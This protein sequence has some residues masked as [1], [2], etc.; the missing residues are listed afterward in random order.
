MPSGE[1][2]DLKLL[3]KNDLEQYVHLEVNDMSEA[4]IDKGVRV[5]SAMLF[6]QVS[7]Y[8][9][10]ADEMCV[11]RAGYRIE[12]KA[13]DS[14]ANE[15]VQHYF[16][17]LIRTM[18][19]TVRV[20]LGAY[21]CSA[22]FRTFGGTCNNVQRPTWG[23]VRS[24]L[25]RGEHSETVRGEPVDA[26][27]RQ[28][29]PNVRTVSREIFSQTQSVLSLRKV[30]MMAVF[31]GQYIDHDMGLSPDTEDTIFEEHMDIELVDE[32]DSMRAKH[33]DTMNFVRSRPMMDGKSCCGRGINR[34]EPREQWNDQTSFI[35]GSQVYGCHR[36][37]VTA[38]RTGNRGLM[39]VGSA[40]ML[41]RNR[42]A[43]IGIKLS[44]AATDSE[45]QFVAGDI[46][47]NEQPVLTSL[48]TLFVREHN[49][50]ATALN[51][52]FDCWSEEQLFHN[53]RKIVSAQIQLI[54]YEHFLPTILGAK[55]G[56]PS[57]NGYKPDVDPSIDNFFSTCAFRF[58]HSMV[59]DTLEVLQS[60]G[61]PHKSNGTLLHETFF[62]P[63]FTSSIGIE[64][65]LL[66]TTHQ[67]AE[68]VDT[69][70]VNSLQNELFRELTGGIDL[71]SLNIQRG[72]DHEQPLYNAARATYGLLSR[73]TFA[74]VTRD[75]AVS[76]K[77]ETLYSGP[78]QLDAFV[79]G[80]A[81]DHVEGS[82]LGELFHVAVREQFARLRDGDKFFYKRLQW[83]DEMLVVD[84]VMEIMQSSLKLQ[85]IIV[86]NSEGKLKAA[87][88]NGN[89]FVVE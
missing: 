7:P 62:S 25:R 87:D 60:R 34:R 82:E 22:D 40:H 69:L 15:H 50:I 27:I 46:R 4:V 74:N 85:D 36:D 73:S 68:R 13:E 80:L 32:Q 76:Q 5:S 65:I 29:I 10:K 37:R 1:W 61:D 28:G 24:S 72:R 39:R 11:L 64:P 2:M 89:V 81:E 78:D 56:L 14:L 18:L 67:R 23:S 41:P 79:G 54:T 43:D 31:W 6:M 38:L 70:V 20:R 19:D 88:F 26:G 71:V 21:P 9:G 77:L 35:D 33:G 63:S 58:G 59:S 51:K 12:T 52:R 49:R 16:S 42:V 53:T 75:T 48:H 45:E 55:H 66:G 3:H 30:S 86:R 83:P 17:A 57:Y 8:A 44:N 47:A 84:E